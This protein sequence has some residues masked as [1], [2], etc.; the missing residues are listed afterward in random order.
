[1]PDAI[2]GTYTF[3]ETCTRGRNQE[4]LITGGS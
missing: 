2:T 4:I 3:K 1:M